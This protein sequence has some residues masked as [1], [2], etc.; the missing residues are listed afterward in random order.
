V[1]TIGATIPEMTGA[2]VISVSATPSVVAST[3]NIQ[4]SYRYS[5]ECLSKPLFQ[6]LAP[7]NIN[8]TVLG[9]T[10]M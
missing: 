9:N 7:S 5:D 8:A 2:R 3:A 1:R 6:I 10:L 4:I